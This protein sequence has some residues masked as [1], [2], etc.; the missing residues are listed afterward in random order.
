MLHPNNGRL[1]HKQLLA[2]TDN[3]SRQKEDRTK[4]LFTNYVSLVFVGFF[5]V[6]LQS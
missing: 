4:A 5:T 3:N 2:L 1:D 6:S